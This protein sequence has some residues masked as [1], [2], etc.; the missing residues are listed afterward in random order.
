[1]LPWFGSGGT[2]GCG[3]ARQAGGGPRDAPDVKVTEGTRR[4]SAWQGVKSGGGASKLL[5]S[6]IGDCSTRLD[7]TAV[8]PCGRGSS[9]GN[10][11]GEQMKVEQKTEASDHDG[12]QC[13]A[14]QS[15]GQSNG[16]GSS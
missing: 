3:T 10:H 13:P 11:F 1:M 15:V 8:S 4:R 14:W 2:A 12:E 5:A 16:K 7:Q 6:P 9:P